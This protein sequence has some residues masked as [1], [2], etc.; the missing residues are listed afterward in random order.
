MST[1]TGRGSSDASRPSDR[2]TAAATARPCTWPCSARTWPPAFF[3]RPASAPAATCPLTGPL[4]CVTRCVAPAPWA[5]RRRSS[6]PTPRRAS[7]AGAGT[8][9][10]ACRLSTRPCAAG[11]TTTPPSGTQCSRRLSLLLW[12]RTCTLNSTTG[13]KAPSLLLG[14]PSSGRAWRTWPPSR[15]ATWRNSCPRT[16]PPSLSPTHPGDGV[17]VV[18]KM[19]LQVAE[20]WERDS[21]GRMTAGRALTTTTLGEGPWARRATGHAVVGPGPACATAATGGTA[22]G[23]DIAQRDRGPAGAPSRLQWLLRQSSPGRTSGAFSRRARGPRAL[24]RGCS[25]ASRR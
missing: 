19:D 24:T 11:P 22:A 17:W 3:S 18:H 7:C 21:R 23:A 9:H 16:S 8:R 14:M 20:A 13:T 2:S 6:Q 25:V 15:E 1:R 10:A 4:C 12:P 5:S